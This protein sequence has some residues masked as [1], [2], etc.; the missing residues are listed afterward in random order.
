MGTG[1]GGF[2]WAP[3]PLLGT[4]WT[5]FAWTAVTPALSPLPRLEPLD[6]EAPFTPA[7]GLGGIRYAISAALWFIVDCGLMELMGLTGPR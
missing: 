4:R 1:A 7:R 5:G 3:A 6:G 2:R